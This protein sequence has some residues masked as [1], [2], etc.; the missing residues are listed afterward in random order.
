MSN[1]IL[2]L[3][4]TA[5]MCYLALVAALFAFQEQLI[6][7]GSLAPAETPDKFPNNVE[8]KWLT[9]QVEG[10]AVKFRVA[11]GDDEHPRAV[12]VFF[13]GNGEGMSALLYR[14]QQFQQYGFTVVAPEPPGYGE[15]PGPM[16]KHDSMQVAQITAKYA[17]HIAKKNS[18]ELFIVGSSIGTFSALELTALGYG[19]RT[20]LHAPLTSMVDVASTLYWH[21]PV[22]LAL[23]EHLRFDNAENVK[24]IHNQNKEKENNQKVLIIHGDQDEIVPHRCGV[25]IQQQLGSSVSEL[26]TARGYDHN[27][28]PLDRNG[29][30]GNLIDDFF[31][32]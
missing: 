1:A 2:S 31:F 11:V 19:T 12:L 30:F 5:G 6:F 26:V 32:R 13:G 9:R 20:I 16:G 17:E 25:E 3:V 21:M 27:S 4:K 10:K 14:C 23:K 29:I 28:V 18:V 24:K 8:I 22:S 7:V 15:S